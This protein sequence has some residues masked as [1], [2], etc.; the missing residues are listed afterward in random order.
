MK[1]I[2]PLLF[3]VAF[4]L[5]PKLSFAQE[6]CNPTGTVCGQ[7][8]YDTC[9]P[10]C[11]GADAAYSCYQSTKSNCRGQIYCN[12]ENSRCQQTAPPTVT[13]PTASCQTDCSK[14]QTVQTCGTL[15]YDTCK[16][17][18]G[19]FN[20][21]SSFCQNGAQKFRCFAKDNT[22]CT[23]SNDPNA[24]NTYDYSCSACNSGLPASTSPSPQPTLTPSTTPSVNPSEKP[25]P[26]KP[27]KITITSYDQVQILDPSTNLNEAKIKL[28]FNE[29]SIANVRFQVDYSNQDPQIY[30]VQY[31]LVQPKAALPSPDQNGITHLTSC[32]EITKSGNYVLDRDLISTD[33]ACIDIRNI[34]D[35]NLDCNQHTI[36]V[37]TLGPSSIYIENVKNFSIKSCT[38]TADSPSYSHYLAIYNSENGI[39][40]SNM[41]QNHQINMTRTTNIQIKNNNFNNSNFMQSKAKNSIIDNNQFLITKDQEWFDNGSIATLIWSIQ[42]SGN[43]ITNNKIDGGSDGILGNHKG[44]DDGIVLGADTTLEDI[45]Q[46][47]SNDLVQNNIISNIYDCGIETSGL[48]QSITISNNTIENSG[49]CGIG[50]WWSSSWI[51]NNIINNIVNNSFNAFSFFWGS[52]TPLGVQ[53]NETITF[54]DNTFKNNKF[55]NQKADVYFPPISISMAT[56]KIPQEKKILSNNIFIGNDFGITK[57]PPYFYPTSMIVDGGNNICTQGTSSDFP[58]K[59]SGTQPSSVTKL[60]SVS[61]QDLSNIVKNQTQKIESATKNS[62]EQLPQVPQPTP[63]S[64]PGSKDCNNDGVINAIDYSLSFLGRC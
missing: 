36:S 33:F 53:P 50:A 34:S 23:S 49:G 46:G 37:N 43:K 19:Q 59:C 44:S 3:L 2:L 31:K 7:T 26:K 62:T 63:K 54:K 20:S 21:S 47:E 15:T 61:N 10:I 28:H 52:R 1:K 24:L 41:L 64:A 30:Y 55:T 12:S 48:A 45:F 11:L 5:L 27:V 16:D 51:G 6:A 39:I 14:C 17:D 9:T 56:E 35:V 18:K 38:L 60:Q 29:Q 4:L 8:S 40:Y 22:N 58:L 25:A 32:Q 42:G 13:Q 57:Y